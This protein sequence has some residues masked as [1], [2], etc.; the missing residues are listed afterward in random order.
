MDRV[1]RRL[2]RLT[3]PPGAGLDDRGARRRLH[4]HRPSQGAGRAP[5][6]RAPCPEERPHPRDD[7]PRPPVR[8]PPGRDVHHR[9]DLRPARH[10]HLHAGGH[11]QPRPAGHPGRRAARGHH[12]RVHQPGGGH[13][14]RVPQPQGPG[15]VTAALTPTAPNR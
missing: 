4:P 3:G 7:G 5:G 9:V 6:P 8:L 2:R 1:G 13:P 10:R 15:H 11:H 12:L 14:L